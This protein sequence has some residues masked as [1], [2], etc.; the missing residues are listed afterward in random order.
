MVLAAHHEKLLIEESGI[1]PDVVEAR[2][3]CTVTT[4]SELKRIGFSDPQ[5][6]V[7]ALLVPIHGPTGELVSY[8]IR[9]DV[10]RVGG[11][12]R[13]LKYE[14]PRNS[15]P[16]LDVPLA[17]RDRLDDPSV[18]LFITEG[19]RKVDALAS[20]RLCGLSM[21]GV[22]CWRGSNEH[23]G[24]VALPDWE[25]V[26]L[27][28]RA[29]YLIFDSDVMIKPQVHAALARLKPFLESR[30]AKVTIT[31]LP[32]GEGGKKQGVDDFFVVGNSVDDLL[33][34]ATTELKEPM[35]GEE[36]A[37]EPRTQAATLVR[38]AEDVELF[39]TPDGEA[40]ASLPVEEG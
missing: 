22:W 24:R 28:D 5:C 33:S 6:A 8:Q 19:A 10:P 3:Y 4:K 18:P 12:G 25:L 21:S 2:G 26:A 34:L 40:Y 11:D 30:G 32:S 38:Y 14:S 1:N 39:R 36:F 35:E 23:G 37:E 15:R 7:P 16:A 13:A 27:H 20:R 29:V 9:A 17:V 31:Y